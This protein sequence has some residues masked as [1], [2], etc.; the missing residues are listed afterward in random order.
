M[1]AGILSM[2]DCVISSNSVGVDIG[3]GAAAL[4]RRC[5]LS[6]NGTALLADGCLSMAGCRLWANNKVG[7][8]RACSCAGM[9]GSVG[10]AY[11]APAACWFL[12]PRSAAGSAVPV[13]V[14]LVVS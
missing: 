3:P 11:N 9:E 5:T 1:A 2:S 14:A 8:E 10:A 12:T 7:T 4:L 6:F 13:G